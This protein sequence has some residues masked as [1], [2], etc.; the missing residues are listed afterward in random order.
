MSLPG[1]ATHYVF[2][3]QIV[4]GLVS[5]GALRTFD[6]A[7]VNCLKCRRSQYWRD[8]P[9]SLDQPCACGDAAAVWRGDP[10]G[11][12]TYSCNQCAAA[13]KP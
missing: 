13:V 9:E 7:K 6:H 10:N 2:N 3:G 12:R 8:A 5:S 4:C 1:K 11:L